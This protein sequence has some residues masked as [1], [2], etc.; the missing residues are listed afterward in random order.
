M[1]T[2]VMISCEATVMKLDFMR[3]ISPRRVISLRCAARIA[4]KSEARRPISSSER[5][6]KGN[7]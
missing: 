7:S 6:F 1:V 4:S 2:G 3:S 5:T